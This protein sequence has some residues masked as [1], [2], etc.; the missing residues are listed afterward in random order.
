MPV[1]DVCGRRKLR[2]TVA[3]DEVGPA[4]GS[5][6]TRVCPSCFARVPDEVRCSDF[7]MPFPLTE[8]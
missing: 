4:A 2:F 5:G 8:L 3:E 7:G 6:E 1:R